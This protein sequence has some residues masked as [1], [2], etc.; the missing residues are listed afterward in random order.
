[1]KSVW[2]YSGD[3]EIARGKGEPNGSESACTATVLTPRQMG[4]YSS[5]QY[6]TVKIL[7]SASFFVP[8]NGK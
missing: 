8:K 2:F 7:P 3:R 6:C 1:M 4:V 5:P